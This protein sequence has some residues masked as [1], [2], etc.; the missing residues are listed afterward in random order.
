MAVIVFAAFRIADSPVGQFFP[1]NCMM[2]ALATSAEQMFY[3]KISPI[4]STRSPRPIPRAKILYFR[5]TEIYAF[6][7]PSRLRKRG[8]SR[9]SRT[10]E[11]G[12][13]G[14]GGG[15]RRAHLSWTAKPCGSN[16]FERFQGLAVSTIP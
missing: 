9:S 15:V 12:C 1:A 16:A 11:V 8:A 14:R 6:L 13:G 2:R 10:W 5:F 7:S 4:L 3:S